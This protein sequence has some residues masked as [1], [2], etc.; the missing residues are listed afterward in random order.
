MLLEAMMHT[1][2]V[3]DV[4]RLS[5]SLAKVVVVVMAEIKVDIY[6]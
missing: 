4:Q 2:V 6:K 1:L 5:L 3:V